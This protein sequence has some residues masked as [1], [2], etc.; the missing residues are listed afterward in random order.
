MRTFNKVIAAENI[1]VAQIVQKFSIFSW[2]LEAHYHLSWA[3]W[4]KST[5]SHFIALNSVLI[6]SSHLHLNIHDIFR[7]V[8]RTGFCILH[9]YIVIIKGEP[10]YSSSSCSIYEVG[11]RAWDVSPT[12]EW[13]TN[14]LENFNGSYSESQLPQLTCTIRQRTSRSSILNAHSR[15]CT[16]WVL[17]RRPYRLL[18]NMRRES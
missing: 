8:F 4:M 3:T 10:D 6:L 7:S 13:C 14:K 5:S 15:F 11:A 16:Y 1:I 12:G 2:I 9:L 18:Y 17:V